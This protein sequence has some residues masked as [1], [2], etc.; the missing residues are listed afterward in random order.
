MNFNI[1]S[2][3]HSVRRYTPS[4]IIYL[5]DNILWGSPADYI[6]EFRNIDE[7]V[8]SPYLFNSELLT[9][10][11]PTFNYYVN[12]QSPPEDYA[13][14]AAKNDN[15]DLLKIIVEYEELNI[16]ALLYQI[17]RVATGPKLVEYLTVIYRD[18]I[19]LQRLI[20]KVLKSG[21]KDSIRY[22]VDAGLTSPSSL[23]RTGDID[24]VSRYNLGDKIDIGLAF[25]SGSREMIEYVENN[26]NL[27]SRHI[28]Y[29]IALSGNVS[30]MSRAISQ[31]GYNVI[32]V[33]MA[34][35]SGSLNMVMFTNK[36]NKNK[37]IYRHYDTTT[38]LSIYKYIERYRPAIADDFKN[39]IIRGDLSG[40]N[41]L[42]D[43]VPA[44][45]LEETI[46]LVDNPRILEVILDKGITN[47]WKLN[48][49]NFL[50][51]ARLVRERGLIPQH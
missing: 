12:L 39:F 49:D 13:I 30:L 43:R 1:E 7:S 14:L 45:I 6:T 46:P 41:Y 5:I 23:I 22:L 20:N 18:K 9:Q 25:L 28:I 37:Y 21:N 35:E 27:M 50:Q 38:S 24:L 36:Y 4:Y 34:I 42:I 44:P 11:N 26:Y 15:I 19:P 16:E 47:I 48:P 2:G 29:D 10:Y 40:V 17:I 32:N 51:L 33:G 31:Y 8:I 3:I